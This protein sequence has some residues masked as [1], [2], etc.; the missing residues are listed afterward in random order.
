MSAPS[1][2]QEA[3]SS[4]RLAEPPLIPTPEPKTL[5]MMLAGLA[6]LGLAASRRRG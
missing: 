2:Q 3:A 5:A 6:A 4:A 1:A